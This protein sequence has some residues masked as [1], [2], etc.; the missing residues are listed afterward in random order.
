MHPSPESR[1]SDPPLRVDVAL[2]HYPVVNRL[3]ET[4]ASA[5]DE[6][7][8]FDGNRLT[9]TYGI[10]RL[11][12]VNPIEAQRE[13]TE[14]LLAHG[15]SAE[16]EASGRIVFDRAC[17]AASLESVLEQSEARGPRPLVVATSANRHASVPELGFRRLRERIQAGEPVLLVFGKAW[18]LAAE[19]IAAADVRLPPVQAQVPYNHLSVRSAMAIVLDRLLTSDEL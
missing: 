15:A 7:D 1:H 12:I 17:W 8:V 18:G 3:G 6:F 9:M 14:R 11:W 5:V 19:A 4:I 13:L 10:H 2:L 16:R